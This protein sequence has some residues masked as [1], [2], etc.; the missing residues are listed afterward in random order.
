MGMVESYDTILPICRGSVT[1]TRRR[2]DGARP[3]EPFHLVDYRTRRMRL[4]DLKQV[5]TK[6]LAAPYTAKYLPHNGQIVLGPETRVVWA[7]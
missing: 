2:G 6:E 5:V 3:K 7:V 4:Q 1:Y